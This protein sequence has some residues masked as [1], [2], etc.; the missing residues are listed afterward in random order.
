VIKLYTE[1]NQRTLPLQSITQA[2]NHTAW[3]YLDTCQ[4]S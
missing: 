3:D 2:V 4:N 1:S